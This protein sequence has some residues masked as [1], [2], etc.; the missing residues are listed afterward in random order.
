MDP[1]LLEMVKT[2]CYIIA[3]KV[4]RLYYKGEFRLNALSVVYFCANGVVFNWCSY[5]LEELL[6]ACMEYQE[7]GGTFTYGYLLLAFT[8]LK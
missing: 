6:M 8:M 2:G 1:I 7:K 4:M 3:N 5:L